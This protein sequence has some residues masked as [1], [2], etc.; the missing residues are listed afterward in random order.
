MFRCIYKLKCVELMVCYIL[1]VIN[2]R[3]NI[4]DFDELSMWEE[5]KFV[6]FIF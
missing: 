1:I 5:L 2:N 4:F 3:W 6:V